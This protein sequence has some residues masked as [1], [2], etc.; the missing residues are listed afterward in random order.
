MTNKETLKTINYLLDINEDVYWKSSLYKV[1]RNTNNK[2]LVVC[3]KNGFTMSLQDT[4]IKDCGTHKWAIR[5][6]NLTN[7]NLIR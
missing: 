7:F 5:E 6:H 2:L 3:T 1:V 4:E